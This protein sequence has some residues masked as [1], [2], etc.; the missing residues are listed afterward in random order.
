MNVTKI[1]YGTPSHD[2]GVGRPCA[3]PGCTSTLSRYNPDDTCACHVLAFR[4]SEDHYTVAPVTKSKRSRRGVSAR[5][6]PSKQNKKAV[7]PMIVCS[8]C[9]QEKP[10]NRN[11]FHAREGSLRGQCKVCVNLH[12]GKLRL[13]DR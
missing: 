13:A 9:G 2:Y 1:K 7:V 10:A 3:Y 8:K 5:R 4:P 11:F 12:R 6:K